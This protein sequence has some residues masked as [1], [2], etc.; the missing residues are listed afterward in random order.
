[1]PVSEDALKSLEERA[2]LVRRHIVRTISDAQAGH[3]GGSLSAAD[4]LVALYFHVLRID[5]EHPE[6]P[7]R[8]RFILSKGHAAAG[9]YAALAECGF[10]P[11]EWLATFG[12][13]DTPLQVHPD[14]LKV[15]GVEVSTGALGQGLS[16]GVGMALG[17]RLDGGAFRTYVLIG[18]GECQEGQI[19]EAAMC[20]AHYRLRELTAILDYNDVQLLG[21]VPEIMEI[22][23]LADKWRAF[24]WHVIEIDGHDMAQILDAFECA[25]TVQDRPTMIL[26]HTV[27]GKGVSFM[28]GKAAWHG[29]PPDPDERE[30]AL[31]DLR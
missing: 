27:K 16:V 5:P 23:P 13:I 11:P 26:A 17:A 4:I 10:F 2:A 31:S 1:M 22:A 15:P 8:D 6:A 21:P 12:G 29:K 14:R 18:D 19:W 30:Q 20:A 24:G 3:P 25:R 28:E 9:L 7:D